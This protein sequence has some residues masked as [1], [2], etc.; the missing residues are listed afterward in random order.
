MEPG[1]D[2]PAIFKKLDARIDDGTQARTELQ[3]L[4]K[5]EGL[6]LDPDSGK[7]WI[8]PGSK[9]EEL[10]TYSL[11][12]AWRLDAESALLSKAVKAPAKNK[13]LLQEAIASEAF[14]GLVKRILENGGNLENFV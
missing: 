7:I 11:V 14:P 3:K 9:F 4:L 10:C 8:P 12:E 13:E 5:E 1:K 2:L 6:V